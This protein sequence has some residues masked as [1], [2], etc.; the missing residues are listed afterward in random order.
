MKGLSVVLG[1]LRVLVQSQHLSWLEFRLRG[2]GVGVL[3][4]LCRCNWDGGY[5]CAKT[6]LPYEPPC[7]TVSTFLMG[8]AYAISAYI[9]GSPSP[10]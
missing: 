1:I 3:G 7:A 2:R 9:K 10:R 8:P 4:F 5:P 6:S